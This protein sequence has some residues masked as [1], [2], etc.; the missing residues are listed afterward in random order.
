M[1]IVIYK[2][3]NESKY[4]FVKDDLILYFSSLRYLRMFERKIENFI[5]IYKDRQIQKV[6]RK[7]IEIDVEMGI[8]PYVLLYSNV[9]YRGFYIEYKGVSYSCLKS[10]RLVGD[11]VNNNY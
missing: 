3:L 6:N 5:E 8:V 1:K 9:E 7:D 4:K 11:L 2:D 10:L